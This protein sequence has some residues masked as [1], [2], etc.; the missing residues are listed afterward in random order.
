MAYDDESMSGDLRSAVSVHPYTFPMYAFAFAPSVNPPW[1]GSMGWVPCN[2]RPWDPIERSFR[3]YAVCQTA[4]S[5]PRAP[6][7]SD[8]RRSAG[9]RPVAINR[10]AF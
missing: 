9:L 8:G 3:D 6:E 5:L 2:L 7:R 4:C 10:P 1:R